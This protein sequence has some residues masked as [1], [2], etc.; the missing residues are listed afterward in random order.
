MVF[1]GADYEYSVEGYLNT[2]RE[3]LIFN[4]CPQPKNT[5]VQQNWVKKRP[6]LIQTTLDG[7]AQKRFSVL[8][9]EIKT[10]WKRIAQNVIKMFESEQIKQ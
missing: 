9:I 2:N 10:K 4:I 1:T 3:N 5:T 7:A 8:P 6:A